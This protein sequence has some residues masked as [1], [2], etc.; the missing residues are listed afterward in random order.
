MLH[1]TLSHPPSLPSAGLLVAFEATA[2]VDYDRNQQVVSWSS[3]HGT[4]W[5]VARSNASRRANRD[6][7]SANAALDATLRS[8]A[9]GLPGL[10]KAHELDGRDLADARPMFVD[11]GEGL[12]ALEFDGDDYLELPVAY[13]PHDGGLTL[14]A[15]LR[16]VDD[17]T[18]S[19][20]DDPQGGSVASGVSRKRRP[21]ST[22]YWFGMGSP[23][24][25]G[26]VQ[27]SVSAIGSQIRLHVVPGKLCPATKHSDRLALLYM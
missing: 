23:A 15:L 5:S 24:S 3:S 4:H 11:R 16:L 17:P 9:H 20:Q 6:Q 8:E 7:R 19:P 27:Y 14:V 2:G 18:V 21:H 26:D 1:G 25:S 13:Q 22:R 12:A 10:A